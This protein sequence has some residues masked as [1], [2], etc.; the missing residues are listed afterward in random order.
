MFGEFCSEI[1]HYTPPVT[2]HF[3]AKLTIFSLV[4]C[5]VLPW[6]NFSHGLIS[7][8]VSCYQTW[9]NSPKTLQSTK[10]EC[11]NVIS[12]GEFFRFSDTN[13]SHTYIV[14]MPAPPLSLW[15]ISPC[16]ISRCLIAPDQQ[17]NQP[18]AKIS[19]WQKQSR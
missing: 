15:R 18:M 4:I 14:S 10:A 6:A 12:R 17:A 11:M 16:L 5:F 8:L 1:T 19:P 7:L 13:T 2:C 9:A 3:R